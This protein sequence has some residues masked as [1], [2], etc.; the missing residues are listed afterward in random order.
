MTTISLH[1]RTSLITG[2]GRGIGAEIARAFAAA[3]ANLVLIGRSADQLASVA[4]QAQELG[5]SARVIT[6]DLSQRKD[7]DK[8]IAEAGAIDI[9]VN[10]ASVKQRYLH[11]TDWPEDYLREAFEVGFW[12]P[13]I[14]MREIGKSM[15]ARK[16][17]VILNISS[18]AGVRTAPHLGHYSAFKAAI[19]M[20]TRATAI[21]LARFGVR[22]L[23]IA[24]GGIDTG[25]HGLADSGALCAPV[26]RIGLVTDVA[27][28]AT[29]LASDAASF[30]TGHVI[31]CDGGLSA[32]EFTRHAPPY[33]SRVE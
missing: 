12:A 17:G 10:N 1:G 33:L 11:C 31:P 2:G 4:A 24:P 22:A 8:V 18:T 20:V 29:F 16:S 21:E 32:G 27:Q 23:S 5:V 9:L 19:D 3:G 13:A 26:G 14:L 30:M 28:L 25:H 6:A 15:A 7:L